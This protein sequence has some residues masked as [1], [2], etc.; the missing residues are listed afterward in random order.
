M[1]EKLVSI[2][3]PAYNAEKLIAESIDSVLGQT[4]QNWELLIADNNSNDNTAKIIKDYAVKDSRIKYIKATEGQT[5]AFARNTSIKQ[6]QGAFIA[7]LD[8]DDLWLPEKLEKHIAF[9]LKEDLYLSYTPYQTFGLREAVV[10]KAEQTNYKDM[11]KS[12]KIGCL[13][14]IYNA[15]KLGKK[16]YMP[17]A[18]KM[19][20]DWCLWCNILKDTNS[21]AKSYPQVLAKYRIDASSL[22]GNK[23]RAAYWHYLALR[24]VLKVN[25]FK[26]WY[27]FIIYAVKGVLG[28]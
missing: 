16:Y 27:C 10:N 4:Y 14:A 3:M 8:S 6:A 21:M 15:E 22:S 13:T 23:A 12:C 7:F 1:T 9:M 18:V 24:K 28:K 11:L 19:S 25:L 26:A 17:T 20:E 5:A 2:I